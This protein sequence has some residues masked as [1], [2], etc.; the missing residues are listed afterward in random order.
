MRPRR[1]DRHS[2][3]DPAGHVIAVPSKQPSAAAID[4]LLVCASSSD[5][6]E[7]FE[8]PASAYRGARLR[9]TTDE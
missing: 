4:T 1:T 5:G 7:G 8:V 2:I 6:H 9:D 3:R